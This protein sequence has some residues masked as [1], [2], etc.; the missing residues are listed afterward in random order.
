MAYLLY[1]CDHIQENDR[2]GF[3]VGHPQE[4]AGLVRLSI[5]DG[6]LEVGIRYRGLAAG[7]DWPA[8]IERELRQAIA[9]E[10]L[11]VRFRLQSDVAPA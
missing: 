1:L 3:V 11:F 7:T 10:P 6:S 5:D 8:K 2:P 4:G 9:I